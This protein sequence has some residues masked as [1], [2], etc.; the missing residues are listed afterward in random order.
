[1]QE[2]EQNA[3]GGGGG[4]LQWAKVWFLIDYS[5]SQLFPGAN[6]LYVVVMGLAARDGV[7][8][9]IIATADPLEW[10]ARKKTWMIGMEW[11][12]QQWSSCQYWQNNKEISSWS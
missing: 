5:R 3:G 4:W 7:E 12:A 10:G 2:L 1:M 9:E 11:R 8:V 6:K